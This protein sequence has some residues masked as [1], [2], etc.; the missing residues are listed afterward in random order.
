MEIEHFYFY[1]CFFSLGLS[2]ALLLL[3][4]VARGCVSL[5]IA[6]PP[7]L[8]RQQQ[9]LQLGL[10]SVKAETPITLP[11]ESVSLWDCSPI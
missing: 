5:A 8:R 1:I 7:F 9:S 2:N 4:Q 11:F 3:T 6:G 10:K